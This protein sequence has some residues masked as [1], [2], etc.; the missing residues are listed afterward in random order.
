MPCSFTV[1][2]RGPGNGA[3][4]QAQ[5]G[6]YLLIKQAMLKQ[7]STQ[8]ALPGPSGP[9]R[10]FRAVIKYFTGWP[11]LFCV[12]VLVIGLVNLG[13]L[14]LKALNPL[15]LDYSEGLVLSGIHRLLDHPALGDT[16]SFNTAF[17]D[18]TDL[19]YPPVF[20][21]LGALFDR[22]LH[23]LPGLNTRPEFDVSV[24]AVR[25]LTLIGLLS[26]VAL[27]YATTRLFK[28][29]R[30]VALA[31]G[32]LFFCF[33][34]VIYWG[35]AGRVDALGLAFVL[36]GVYLFCRVEVLRSQSLVY[37]WSI[38]FFYLAFFTKQSLLAAAAAVVLYLLV[39]RR[40][41]QAV[42][43]A[44][45]LGAGIGLGL[46]G[47]NLATGGNYL[48][49]V[50]MERFT[51][52]SPGQLV[53]TWALS[54]LLYGPLIG[55]SVW[56]GISY[57]RQGGPRRFLVIWG[58][59]A[60]LVSLTVGK[61][62]AADYYFFEFFAFLGIMA[63]LALSPTSPVNVRHLL[64]KVML[65]LQILILLVLAVTL[66]FQSDRQ[67]NLG[68]A[69]NEAVRVLAGYPAGT[70]LFAELSGP[71]M[72]SGHFDQV[73]DHF[74][75]R[76]LSNAGVRDGQALVRDVAGQKFKV[77]LMGYDV[78]KLNAT[79]GYVPSTPWPPGFEEAVRDHYRLLE[80]LQGQDGQDY[81]WLL[82]PK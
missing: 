14:I 23:A 22:L 9:A 60:F 20:P 19:A 80:T 74:L 27:V 33:H 3:I 57:F 31:A 48:F 53:T 52:F 67:A 40:F 1:T 29:P 8:A 2:K 10:N 65:G 61:A 44:G 7:D 49:F 32:I 64:P 5:T 45:L 36:A 24:Y 70:P 79:V 12:A 21:Y 78:L 81:A 58:G 59:C 30:P 35:D 75:F 50:T 18:T 42:I 37:L 41:K 72:A 69:Y 77:M 47:L 15:Q 6:N 82:V 55:L 39:S 51:P 68:P 38:P 62:G 16:Y 46:A 43:F 56:Q 4:I 11:G 34:P 17:Y 76:Q 25:A 71:A 26:S 73:F 54:L 66:N 13:H 63:G 28:T